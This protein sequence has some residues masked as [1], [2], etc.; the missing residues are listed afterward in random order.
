ME[1]HEMGEQPTEE[2]LEAVQG[3]T[4]RVPWY[5]LN[6]KYLLRS[7]WTKGLLLV[8]VLA[9]LFVANS[10]KPLW[11]FAWRHH[12]YSRYAFSAQKT[13][14]GHT[15]PGG[16]WPRSNVIHVYGM[17]GVHERA[18]SQV[19]DGLRSLIQ[20]FGL[21]LEVQKITTPPDALKSYAYAR[22]GDSF[23]FDR[24]EAS[25][26]EL[27]GEQYGEMVV[28][29]RHF[30]DPSWA[31]GL[32]TFAPGLAVLQ[33]SVSTSALGRHEGAHLLGYGM[34]DDYP[35]YVLGYREGLIPFNRNTLMMLVPTSSDQLSGRARDALL[36]FWQGMEARD[37]QKYF[38]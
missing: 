20:D 10:A 21:T 28:V 29:D 30:T 27:R 32:S 36:C 23:D 16:T 12:L 17:P 6:P 15:V 5:S 9:F 37:H 35:F 19:A 2:S 25:R 7:K 11:T 31:F 14:S 13:Q 1:V 26:L 24:F 8:A 38:R 22:R 4:E 33:A 3:G 18:V 34:H